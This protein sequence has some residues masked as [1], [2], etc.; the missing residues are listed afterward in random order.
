MRCLP[1]GSTLTDALIP[2]TTLFRSSPAPCATTFAYGGPSFSQVAAVA[3][4]G[5]AEWLA[6]YL[7]P[8]GTPVMQPM[9][10]CMIR[11]RIGPFTSVEDAHAALAKVH[12]AGYQEARIV[13][14]AQA[15]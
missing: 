4:S 1:P 13:V 10:S 5:R 9:G 11:V 3:D 15:G 6:N 2:Y 7:K 8:Y 14:D 12:N